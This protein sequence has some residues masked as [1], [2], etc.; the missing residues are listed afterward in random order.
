MW[1]YIKVHRYYHGNL[2]NGTFVLS[3]E[4]IYRYVGLIMWTYMKVRL[5]Y[6]VN[7]YKGTCVIFRITLSTR[8]TTWFSI[9]T[10]ASSRVAP[11]TWPREFAAGKR[12]PRATPPTTPRKTSSSS[13]RP[14]RSPSGRMR[15]KIYIINLLKGPSPASF[16]FILVV[17]NKHYDFTTNK[18]E[19]CPSSI[20]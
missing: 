2:H 15:F 9:S 3:C 14:W 13:C 4:P 8:S 16:S 11:P 17:S 7:L 1:T 5:Y 18:C 19:K 10:R 6:H 12:E 20:R